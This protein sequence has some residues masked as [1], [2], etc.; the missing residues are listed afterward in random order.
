LALLKPRAEAQ[1]LKIAE[2]EKNLRNATRAAA[3]NAPAEPSSKK[4]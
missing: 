2:Y 1:R 3:T 4:K